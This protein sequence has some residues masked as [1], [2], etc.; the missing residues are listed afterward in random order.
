MLPRFGKPGDLIDGFDGKKVVSPQ[1]SYPLSLR[2]RNQDAHTTASAG[3]LGVFFS[4]REKKC[5]SRCLSLSIMPNFCCLVILNIIQ[6]VF[7]KGISV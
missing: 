7:W 4:L 5:V 3:N 6:I 1:P 2:Q